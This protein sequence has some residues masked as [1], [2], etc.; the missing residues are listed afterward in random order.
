MGFYVRADA[1]FAGQAR[2]L[3]QI[4]PPVSFTVLATFVTS[5]VVRG[6]IV[7]RA[8]AREKIGR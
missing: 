1:R 5:M 4:D 7:R 6:P 8:P 2:C 3:D